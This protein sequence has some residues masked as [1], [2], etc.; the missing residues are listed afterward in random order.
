MPKRYVC[1]NCKTV[2]NRSKVCKICS[3]DTTVVEYPLT[4]WM[5]FPYL[6]ALVTGG[7]LLIAQLSG[8]YI[9]IWLTFPLIVIGLIVD[10]LNQQKLD[11]MARK[12][13][14]KNT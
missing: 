13:F 2:D 8:Y 10:H 1:D 14:T 4:P 3:E 11:R 9:I 6:M 12:R 7:I 5:V